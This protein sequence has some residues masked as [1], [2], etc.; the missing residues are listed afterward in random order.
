VYKEMAEQLQGEVERSRELHL[1]ISELHGLEEVQ[2]TRA[3]GLAQEK[4]KYA[5]N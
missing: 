2:R 3:L 5:N 4:D 1:K